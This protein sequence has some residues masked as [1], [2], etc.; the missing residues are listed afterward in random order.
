MAINKPVGRTIDLGDGL[1]MH[2][3]LV[4]NK[5]RVFMVGA[6]D[7][8]CFTQASFAK[9]VAEVQKLTVVIPQQV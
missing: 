6:G 9:F 7:G 1:Y 4:D 3:R 2:S 8:L 5:V